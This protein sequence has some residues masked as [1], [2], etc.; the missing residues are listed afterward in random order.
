MQ[1]VR[2]GE[3]GAPPD[4]AARSEAEAP[5]AAAAAGPSKRRGGGEGAEAYAVEGPGGLRHAQPSM[6]AIPSKI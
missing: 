2:E 6:G 1:D 5:T 4:Q 3:G